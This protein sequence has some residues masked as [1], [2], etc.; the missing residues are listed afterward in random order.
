MGTWD[1]SAGQELS[2]P[3]ISMDDLSLPL[4]HSTSHPLDAF[5][6]R[7]LSDAV[8]WSVAAFAHSLLT[9]QTAPGVWY[10]EER[11]ALAD[12]RAFLQ[13][14]S[15]GCERFDLNKPAWAMESE[16]SSFAGLIYW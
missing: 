3:T 10:P 15:T 7:R 5:P 12:R 13:L 14:A 4:A 8:G 9:G 11:E 1:L 2:R 16:V 6:R